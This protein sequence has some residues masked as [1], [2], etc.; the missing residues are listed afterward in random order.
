VHSIKSKVQINVHAHAYAMF[1]LF[2]NIQK[3]IYKK[4]NRFNCYNLAMKLRTTTG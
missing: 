1:D 2:A 3:F 4:S